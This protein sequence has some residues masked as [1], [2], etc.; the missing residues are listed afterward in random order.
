[1][2]SYALRSGEQHDAK[3]KAGLREAV[4]WAKP[5]VQS[6]RLAFYPPEEAR[7]IEVFDLF[8][9]KETMLPHLAIL[10][11]I[12]WPAMR[13]RRARHREGFREGSSSYLDMVDRTT[14]ELVGT[15]GFREVSRGTAEFGIVVQKSRQREGLCS[16]AFA[17]NVE[18]ARSA[19]GC[20][21]VTAS[22]SDQNQVM[23]SFLAS[24][25]MK[26]VGQHED[27]G[28][29]WVEF[30]ADVKELQN[31]ALSKMKTK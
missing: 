12:S 11:P 6:S 30:S 16:E 17:C 25:G 18:F 21:R 1:M 31:I 4:E 26:R 9:D 7:D 8:N 23:L 2:G 28:V 10:C 29:T 5:V 15:A 24:R 27:K 20:H 13:S 22:T 19:L 3:G 14:G